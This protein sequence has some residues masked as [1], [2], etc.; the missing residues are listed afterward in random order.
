MK[1]NVESVFP[2][3]VS[4]L[5]HEMDSEKDFVVTKNLWG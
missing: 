5:N 3:V 1:Y 4:K 2:L